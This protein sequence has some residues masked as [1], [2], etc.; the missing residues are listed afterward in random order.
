MRKTILLASALL[1]SGLSIAQTPSPTLTLEDRITQTALEH[2]LPISKEATG[3]SGEGWTSLLR[4]GAEAQF[5]LIGEEHGIAE[6]PVMAASLFEALVPSGFSKLVVE[7]SPFMASRLDE[8]LGDSGMDGLTALFS[9]PGGEP[10][11]FGMREEAEMLA[12]VRESVPDD[13]QAFWGVDYEVLGDRQML[14]ALEAMDKPELAQEALAALRDASNQSWAQ[15]EASRKP[16]FIFSFSGDPDLVR[17]VEQAWPE[18]SEAA[19]WILDQLEETLEINRLYVSGKGFESNRV[20]AKGFRADFLRHWQAADRTNG[21]P[22]L[23]AKLGA[24]HLVRG[25]NSN[26]V[27]DLGATLH[28]V[29]AL[30]GRPVLSLMVLPGENTK[31]ALFDPTTLSFRDGPAKDGYGEGMDLFYQAAFE[32]GFTLFDLRPLRPLL[33]R[34]NDPELSEL[35]RTVHGFDHLLIMT[36]STA[37]SDLN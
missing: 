26:G 24:S 9:E 20:R 33:A 7:V 2:R 14:S 18:R 28:E 23:I 27:F 37:S 29:A 13:E 34:N 6:N 10:A 22:R 30:E 3:F 8:A 19:V 4:Q 11:F 1:L 25:R 12:R 16:Q 5:V 15:Y 17:A 32:T 35:I 21:A 36:G 31:V